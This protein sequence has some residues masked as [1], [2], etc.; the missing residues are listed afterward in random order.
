MAHVVFTAR[1]V[2]LSDVRR[3]GPLGG[4]LELWG[5]PVYDIDDPA[6]PFLVTMT[7]TAHEGR[8]ACGE[9]RLSRRAGGTPV[10]DQRLRTVTVRSY[11][12][13]IRRQLGSIGGGMVIL[14]RAEE[15]ADSVALE[16][17]GEEDVR[18]LEARH[19]I[20]QPT[21]DTLPR[22][23]A[24]YR[25]ALASDD[26]SEREAPTEYVAR[27]LGYSRGHASRLVALARKEGL[28][29]PA[30]PGRAGEVIS[31]GKASARSRRV[32]KEGGIR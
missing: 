11:L 7:V 9:L 30:S 25:R 21:S 8:L 3:V 10:T 20:R 19:R 26:V 12:A 22:V 23:A 13:G 4:G 24:A 32:T 5:E 28:L 2:Q 31:S 18:G 27:Q 17:L 6:L 14:R 15:F 29:G 16:P 1:T